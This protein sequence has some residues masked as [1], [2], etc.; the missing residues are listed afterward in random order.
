LWWVHP[1][2]KPNIQPA[3]HSLP[4]SMGWERNRRKAR[5]L[6]YQGNGSLIGKAKAACTSK[7]K[8]NQDVVHYFSSSGRC[9]AISYREG[10]HSEHAVVALEDKHHNHKHLALFPSPGF[11]Y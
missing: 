11:Y 5:R 7:A 8:H 9:P 1:G 4:S 6:M 2:Q 3:S 10:L